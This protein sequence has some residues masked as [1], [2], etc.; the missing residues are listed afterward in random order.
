MRA[1]LNYQRQHQHQNNVF[2]VV[3]NGKNTTPH[4]TA[5]QAAKAYDAWMRAN[6]PKKCLKVVVLNFFWFCLV[7]ILYCFLI[8][9]LFDGPRILNVSL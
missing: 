5:K 2:K 7:L 3:T 9:F 1:L 4:N 8:A 6:K